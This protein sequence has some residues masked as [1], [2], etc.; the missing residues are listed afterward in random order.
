[1]DIPSK[2]LYPILGFLLTI[3]FGFWLGRRGKPYNGLLFNIHKLIALAAVILAGMEMYRLWKA[4]DAG[5]S[6]V[7]MLGVIAVCVVLL[8]LSGAF[9]SADI[10]QYRVVRLIH[11]VVLIVAVL[12]IL[13]AIYLLGGGALWD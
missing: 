13:S 2:F 6:V 11:N 3:V 1:M 4:L 10:G 7:L 9:M 8:F 5:G 12:A